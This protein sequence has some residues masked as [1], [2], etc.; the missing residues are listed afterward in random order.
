MEL[1]QNALVGFVGLVG[2]WLGHNYRRQLRLQL[3]EHV[4]S[5]YRNLWQVTGLS[6]SDRLSTMTPAERQQL[7]A[8]M[9]DWYYAQGQGML[10]PPADT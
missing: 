5:A 4:L 1:I 8:A 3:T 9:D 7:A 10:L 6:P 2:L